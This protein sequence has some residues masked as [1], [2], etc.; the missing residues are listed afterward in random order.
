ME[1]YL[2]KRNVRPRGLLVPP[3]RCLPGR[4]GADSLDRRNHARG[5]VTPR[6]AHGTFPAPAGKCQSGF[7]RFEKT[8]DPLCADECRSV[9]HAC[10][11]PETHQKAPRLP[12]S[13][14]G[15]ILLTQSTTTPLTAIILPVMTHAPRGSPKYLLGK[16]GTG[17]YRVLIFNGSS[18]AEFLKNDCWC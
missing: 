11:A 7:T 3:E 10:D 9:G 2:R 14:P 12:F 18:L 15:R 4:G 6:R 17:I 5:G 1:F 16:Q 13:L 8:G